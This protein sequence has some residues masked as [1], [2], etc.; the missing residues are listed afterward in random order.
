[1]KPSFSLSDALGAPFRLTANRPL[2][3]FVW[4]MLMLAMMVATYAL[5]IPLFA[6]LPLDDADA[7]MEGYMA[8]A[9]AVSAFSNLMTVVMYGVMLMIFTGS[10]RAALNPQARS[11]FFFL[12]LGMDEVRAAVAIVALFIGWYVALV[13]LAM[14]GFALGAAFWG[15]GKAVAIP[16]VVIY[17]LAVLVLSIWAW[18]RVSL[19]APAGVIL[20]RFAFEEGWRIARGQVWKLVGMNILLWLIYMV[21]YVATLALAAAILAGGFMIQGLQWPSDVRTLADLA[22]VVQPMILPA[23]VAALPMAFL[24][25]WLTTLWS[26]PSAVAARQLLDGTPASG[27][28][29]AVAPAPTESA[30]QEI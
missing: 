20:G 29:E 19:I 16:V 25:G 10:I 18:C 28:R 7:A 24:F 9:M 12:K 17:G 2:T 15:A 27:E 5:L 3:V 8:E 30:P 26:V 14:I 22:P 23:V 21:A 13:I 1:M 4:G 11:R 6:N